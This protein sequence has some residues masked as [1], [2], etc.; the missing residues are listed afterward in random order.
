MTSQISH[1]QSS[2]ARPASDKPSEKEEPVNRVDADQVG[3]YE[4]S[5]DAETLGEGIQNAAPPLNRPQP[6]KLRPKASQK[7]QKVQPVND[8]AEPWSGSSK[9]IFELGQ[10]WLPLSSD[11]IHSTL[12][13]PLGISVMPCAGPATSYRKRNRTPPT[14][15]K[16]EPTSQQVRSESG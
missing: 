16:I 8:P 6:I 9:G 13:C 4:E 5:Q 11:N 3:G 12:A 15:S 7:K 14:Q 1:G 10:K 2:N